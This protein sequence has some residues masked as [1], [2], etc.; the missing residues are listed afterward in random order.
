MKNNITTALF[1]AIVSKLYE[2]CILSLEIIDRW[3]KYN[4]ISNGIIVTQ[5]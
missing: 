2:Q 3:N 1:T 4:I 5:Y